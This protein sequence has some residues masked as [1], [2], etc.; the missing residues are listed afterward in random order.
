MVSSPSPSPE[1]NIFCRIHTG[2]PEHELFP[3]FSFKPFWIH[4][5]RRNCTGSIMSS[6]NRQSR[7]EPTIDPQDDM[8]LQLVL[9]CTQSFTVYAEA[10]KTPRYIS[11]EINA[12]LCVPKSVQLR[13]YCLHFLSALHAAFFTFFSDTSMCILIRFLYVTQAMS[14][15]RHSSPQD[16]V[17][18]SSLSD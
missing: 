18:L 5:R 16:S 15:M 4:A 10:Y 14:I 8:C 17:C 11:G 1:R 13:L 3:Y 6:P 7:R 2:A 9:L 12:P